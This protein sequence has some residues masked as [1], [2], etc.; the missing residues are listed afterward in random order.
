[1]LVHDPDV[2]AA[3]VAE[4]SPTAQ[5]MPID[6]TTA[7]ASRQWVSEQARA[8]FQVVWLRSDAS[9][10]RAL[11]DAACLRTAGIEVEIVPGV[12]L[13]DAA[14]TPGYARGGP[15]DGFRWTGR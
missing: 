10:V 4:A 13:F 3:L 5:V 9:H 1:V 12:A 11:D 7:S 14:V 2:T 8:G 15:R 6:P